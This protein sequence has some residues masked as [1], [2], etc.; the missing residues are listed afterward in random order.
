MTADDFSL[1]L[2]PFYT[3][4]QESLKLLPRKILPQS[5]DDSWCARLLRKGVLPEDIE[6]LAQILNPDPMRG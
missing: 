4:D 5:E 2:M 3:D 6:F 1:H